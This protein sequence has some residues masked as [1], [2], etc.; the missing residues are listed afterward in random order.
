MDENNSEMDH[1]KKYLMENNTPKM[2]YSAIYRF[3]IPGKP[4]INE[5]IRLNFDSLGNLTGPL[6]EEIP[7]YLSNPS[8]YTFGIDSITAIQIAKQDSLEEGLMPWRVTFGWHGPLI[9]KY[10][11]VVTNCLRLGRDKLPISGKIRVID[12]N[13]W[14]CS[15]AT[16]MANHLLM[17]VRH[18]NK[19]HP[20]DS[21]NRGTKKNNVA[22]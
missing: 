15:R 5:P 11:W 16:N 12:A 4:W 21:S 10:T 22:A 8:S 14:N 9:K 1:P 7:E 13:S 19:S 6:P 2:P 20:F 17:V 18:R 3:T